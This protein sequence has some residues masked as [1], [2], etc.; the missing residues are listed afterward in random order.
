[1]EGVIK[2]IRI[3]KKSLIAI[4][5]VIRDFLTIETGD[6]VLF[7]TRGKNVIIIPIKKDIFDFTGTGTPY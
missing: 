5:K 7:E 2:P 3:S 6:T 1:M 4:P